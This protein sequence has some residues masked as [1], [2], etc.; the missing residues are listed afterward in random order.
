MAVTVSVIMPVFNEIRHID[1]SVASLS[2]QDYP[3]S[4]MEW[5][6]VDG[7]STDGTRDKLA[8][9]AAKNPDK[10]RV[11]DNPKR[12]VPYAM[13]I[14]IAASTGKYV[15][16]LDAHSDYAV[17]Y[18]T[19]CVHY[20]DTTDAS[21]V[22][23]IA[24]TK[25][26]GVMGNAIAKM[27]SSKFGVGN[28]GFRTGAPSG[29]TDTVPFGA[30]RREVFATLGG[31]DERLD[32]NE[33]NEINYRI[34]KSGGKVYLASDIRLSYYCRDTVRGI[35]GMAVQNGKW[36]VITMRLCPGSMGLRHFVPLCFVLSIALLGGFGFLFAPL[37][38]ALAAEAG[39]YLLLDMVFSAAKCGSVGR[40]FILLWLF[41]LFHIA[42]GL[43][44]I[45][46]IFK[47]FSRKFSKKY[48]PPIIPMPAQTTT[49]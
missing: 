13:N 22:G 28:S 23:G 26:N 8:E 11:L 45:A 17:D 32:R 47:Q 49:L 48:K 18:I 36:N 4:D 7:G 31:F 15:V 10:I 33:D 24:E 35:T 41:P 34:R 30:F 14:G 9:Y 20:L 42:Y 5:I 2:A 25:S 19:K 46:G 16:R 39:L 38:Y 29:Y 12:T 44:S 27:L 6:F 1:R 43:G 37:W 40:F 3:L 21:N